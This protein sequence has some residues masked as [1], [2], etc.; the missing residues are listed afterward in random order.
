MK[1]NELLRDFFKLHGHKMM[2]AACRT[3]EKYIYKWFEQDGGLMSGAWN[4]LERLLALMRA[5]GDVRPLRRLCEQFNGYFVLNPRVKPLTSG[6]LLR[7]AG[8]IVRELG[9]MQDEVGRAVEDGRMN[10][11]RAAELR[12]RWE[13]MKSDTEC[14]VK[15]C[16]RGIFNQDQTRPDS[17]ARKLPLKSLLMTLPFWLPDMGLDALMDLDN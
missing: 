1:S 17:P 4:P 15:E 9:Q 2:A 5:A 16:E 6:D 10:P 7:A 11:T 3:K 14:Y 13:T 8:H 12:R